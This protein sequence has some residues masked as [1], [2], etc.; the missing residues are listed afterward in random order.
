[1]SSKFGSNIVKSALNGKFWMIVMPILFRRKEK[2]IKKT[3]TTISCGYRLYERSYALWLLGLL[4]DVS[5]NTSV[6]V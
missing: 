2:R 5:Q 3:G 1:M 6:Y 4:S